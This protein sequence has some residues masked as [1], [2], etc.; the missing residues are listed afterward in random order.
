M[1]IRNT[2]FD[3]NKQSPSQKIFNLHNPKL[4]NTETPQPQPTT[5]NTN[6]DKAY[7]KLHHPN[8]L[9]PKYDGPYHI[10]TKHNNNTTLINK[11]QIPTLINNRNIKIINKHLPTSKHVRFKNSPIIIKNY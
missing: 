2:T 5:P 7:I 6:S 10:I 11:N 4:Y 3:P 9:Q 1:G 8:S